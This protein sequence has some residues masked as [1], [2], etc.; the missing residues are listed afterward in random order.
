MI[1]TI[2][3]TKLVSLNIIRFVSIFGLVSV[4]IANAF[5]LREDVI[6]LHQST[7][8]KNSTL[9]HDDC[10]Y[11]EDVSSIPI[12]S[13]GAFRSFFSRILLIVQCAILLWSEIG[14]PQT[15]FKRWIPILSSDHS[16]VGLGI[17]EVWISMQFLAHFL[18]TSGIAF[19]FILF[20]G[21]IFN[22]ATFFV[23]RP[24]HYRS[25]SFYKGNKDEILSRLESGSR[26]APSEVGSGA[27]SI[28]T[29][30]E[31]AGYGFARQDGGTHYI[32]RPL[33]VAPPTYSPQ[34][35]YSR[36]L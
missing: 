18:E 22:L 33:T 1:F 3:L 5:I 34:S 21:G 28:F 30:K 15:F 35:S 11:L 27:A 19:G 4:L 31:G 25:W 9:V 10:E 29:S 14:W 16:L 2:G 20:F 36:Q 26:R 12:G 24:R 32:S 8:H 23:D 6:L 13:L 7:Q 17:F